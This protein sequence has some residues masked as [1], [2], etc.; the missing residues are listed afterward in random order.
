MTASQLQEAMAS[1][2]PI[3]RELQSAHAS[4]KRWGVNLDPDACRLT[5]ALRSFKERLRQSDVVSAMQKIKAVHVDYILQRVYIV[6]KVL[7]PNSPGRS[8]SSGSYLWTHCRRSLR[9]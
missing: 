7:R 2:N 9:D 4:L 6:P 8:M 1:V 3:D 5:L